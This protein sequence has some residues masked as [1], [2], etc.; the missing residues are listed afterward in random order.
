MA[1]VWSPGSLC[2]SQWVGIILMAQDGLRQQDA[3]RLE[4]ASLSLKETPGGTLWDFCFC[5]IRYSVI[6]VAGRC[7]KVVINW[8]VSQLTCVRLFATSWA[9]AHQASLSITVALMGQERAR[10]MKKEHEIWCN[11]SGGLQ[12]LLDWGA[13]STL[14]THLFLIADYKIF[15]DL[16]FFS[17]H[18]NFYFFV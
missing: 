2:H 6:S 14:N 10:R 12:T 15:S 16:I 8:G 9:A 3:G 18:M 17:F 4:N 7:G 11:G 5:H 1:S 13:E